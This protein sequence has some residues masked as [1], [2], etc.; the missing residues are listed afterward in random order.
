VELSEQL[1]AEETENIPSKRDRRQ[2]ERYSPSPRSNE[3]SSE[4]E[5]EEEAEAASKS[6]ASSIN[7]NYSSRHYLQLPNIPM[8]SAP[9]IISELSQSL[10]AVT[11][12]FNGSVESTSSRGLNYIVLVSVLLIKSCPFLTF[13]QPERIWTKHSRNKP[14][15]LSSLACRCVTSHCAML[16]ILP[17]ILCVTKGLSLQLTSALLH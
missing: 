7:R 9:S 1:A 17:P 12:V 8:P 4:S 3:S 11:W 13:Q 15:L 16:L 6:A 2:T 14:N 5:P 10:E